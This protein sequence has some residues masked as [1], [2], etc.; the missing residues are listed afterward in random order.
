[1]LCCSQN[2]GGKAIYITKSVV[3]NLLTCVLL[4]SFQNYWLR[5]CALPEFIICRK[6]SVNHNFSRLIPNLVPH[7][8]CIR[9]ILRQRGNKFWHCFGFANQLSINFAAPSKLLVITVWEI[10][11]S[12]LGDSE[13]LLFTTNLM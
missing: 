12:S 2:S 3:L 1:M 11:V 9:L 6:T 4:Q 10:L 8:A 7:F 5:Q 13:N